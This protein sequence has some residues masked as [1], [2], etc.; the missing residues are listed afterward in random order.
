[1]SVLFLEGIHL[2]ENDQLNNLIHRS[3]LTP[4]ELGMIFYFMFLVDLGELD[5]AEIT[6]EAL[7]QRFPESS[8]YSVR[9][10]LKD[11]QDKGYLEYIPI[12][13][14]NRYITQGWHIYIDRILADC[15]Q[16]DASISVKNTV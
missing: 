12:R 3:R 1:M 15:P 11:L 16:S 4:Q 2:L 6:F 7:Y 10:I 8:V 9:K 13:K 14:K 5:F